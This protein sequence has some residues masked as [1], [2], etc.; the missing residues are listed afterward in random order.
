MI[1]R[2]WA[3]KWGVNRS[4]IATSLF[5]GIIHGSS[6]LF[7]TLLGFLLGLLYLRNGSLWLPIAA[8]VIWNAQAI[9]NPFQLWNFNNWAAALFFIAVGTLFLWL[10]RDTY[11]PRLP[12]T[13]APLPRS[14]TQALASN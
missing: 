3:Y 9:L 1:L 13:L 8:H 10:M 6:F 2:R 7:A 5:F 14:D 4:L 12:L 11:M